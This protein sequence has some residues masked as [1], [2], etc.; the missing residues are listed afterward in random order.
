LSGRSASSVAL[1]QIQAL[2]HALG[3]VLEKGLVDRGSEGI[4]GRVDLLVQPRY[5]LTDL[6]RGRT[7]RHQ[8]M[9]RGRPSAVPEL[10]EFLRRRLDDGSGGEEIEIAKIRLCVSREIRVGHVAPA[11][12]RDGVVDDEGLIMHAM[13]EPAE[14][15]E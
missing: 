12:H 2:A 11:D 3:E 10:V 14:V 1:P 5:H 4:G 8:P 9:D 6:F 15:D 7:L 13:I